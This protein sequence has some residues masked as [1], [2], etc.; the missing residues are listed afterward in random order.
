MLFTLHAEIINSENN[1][2][3]YLLC[4]S[5]SMKQNYRKRK[6]RKRPFLERKPE[7][8]EK[9]PVYFLSKNLVQKDDA[10]EQNRNT[11]ASRNNGN[12]TPFKKSNKNSGN[13]KHRRRN[14]LERK[15][16][17]LEKV[18]PLFLENGNGEVN[19]IPRQNGGIRNPGIGTA[20]GKR[21][22][23]RMRKEQDCNLYFR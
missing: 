3:I 2:H 6:L 11:I 5:V 16:E 19:I 13:A 22:K 9:I 12:P 8:F 10:P 20:S 1:C 14:F 15:P 21:G 18:L 4:L 7:N 23:S 17:N